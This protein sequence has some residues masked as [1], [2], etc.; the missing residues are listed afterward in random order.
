MKFSTLKNA[1]AGLALGLMLYGAP[2][3]GAQSKTVAEVKSPN[4]ARKAALTCGNIEKLD[5]GYEDYS[6]S[7]CKLTLTTLKTGAATV[8]EKE[9]SAGK[10]NP[11]FSDGIEAADVKQRIKWSPDS[12]YLVYVY[13]TGDGAESAINNVTLA[14]HD[15][16]TGKTARHNAGLDLVGHKKY[17]NNPRCVT[18]YGGIEAGKSGIV[19]YTINEYVNSDG[20]VYQ[21]N[22]CENSNYK[23]NKIT[24]GY[25][26]KVI[27][28]QIVKE[29]GFIWG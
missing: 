5:G 25:N 18:P 21:E 4:G 11:V 24:L 19:F 7:R 20:A 29:K 16:K 22:M 2:A 1:A 26:G 13:Y 6:R 14:I 3:C 9:L 12:R 15:T 8:V 17:K 23:I 10:S 28:K 27:K